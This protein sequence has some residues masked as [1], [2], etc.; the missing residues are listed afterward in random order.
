[1]VRLLL[2]LPAF[3]FCLCSRAQ[4]VIE[5]GPSFGVSVPQILSRTYNSDRP[6]QGALLGVEAHAAYKTG[7]KHIYLGAGA[8]LYGF[9]FNNNPSGNEGS[10]AVGLFGLSIGVPLQA[11]FL[12]H[13]GS[14]FYIRTSVGVTPLMETSGL[15]HTSE[16]DGGIRFNLAPDVFAGILLNNRTSFGFNWFM[17]LRPYGDMDKD[18]TFYLHNITFKMQ[19]CLK[20]NYFNK[21]KKKKQLQRP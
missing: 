21:Q 15:V 19:Y 9:Y 5:V 11:H 16:A 6:M 17:P 8:H 18:Y 13:A 7:N 3:F 12:F 20:D 4:D 2:L 14:N 1:M 10:T